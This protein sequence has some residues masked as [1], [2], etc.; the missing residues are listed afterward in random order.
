[1]AVSLQGMVDAKPAGADLSDDLFK[2]A[3]LNADGNLVLAG[4]GEGM[5]GVIT[6]TNV[7]NRPV[8]VQ[9][10]GIAK[11]H[12]G[13]VIVAGAGVQVGAGG[14]AITIGA[15]RR[16]GMARNGVDQAGKLVEVALLGP[17]G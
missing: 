1:M 13:G 3:K 11:I 15:G 5:Y 2:C 6:E 14:L 17:G 12:A 7:I 8:T 9:L 16:I 10:D 4:A